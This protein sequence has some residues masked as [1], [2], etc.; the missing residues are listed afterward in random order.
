MNVIAAGMAILVCMPLS[1]YGASPQSGAI[2]VTDRPCPAA[3][4]ADTLN[5]RLT[6]LLEPGA[7]LLAPD[8]KQR[9]ALQRA[10]A[11]RLSTDWAQLCRYE[12]ENRVLGVPAPGEKRVVFLGDS[13]T[14]FWKLADP[15]LFF[16][17][18]IDRGISG[19]TT[20]QM[21][22]RFRQDVVALH[23][24]AVHLMAGTNDIAGNG[25]PTTLTAI[26]ANFESM[27]ELAEHNGI[28]VVLASV[29]PAADFGW[30]PGLHPAPTIVALNDWLKS[31]A[32]GKGLLYVDYHTA[33]A[34]AGLG[35][36]KAFA[37]DGVHPNRDGYAVMKPLAQVAID[38]V[39]L[40]AVEDKGRLIK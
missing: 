13:I 16:G 38:R 40:Q 20:A 39:R 11:Q 35:L 5:E 10:D 6:R 17:G 19:Q 9:E 18:V 7:T 3:P 30:R 28:A 36:K 24:A 29:P 14:E 2:G 12:V 33:L 4:A 22:V 27:V 21:L 8:P 15:E 31:Y 25:G 26:K 34:D 1:S 32:A 23:P 37:N